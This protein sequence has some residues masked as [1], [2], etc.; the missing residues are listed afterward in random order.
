MTRAAL[1]TYYC[2]KQPTLLQDFDTLGDF[3]TAGTGAAFSIDTTYTRTG[4]GSLKMTAGTAATTADFALPSLT[5]GRQREPTLLLRVYCPAGATYT[6]VLVYLS[7]SA[8]F[9]AGTWCSATKN[10][11]E[12]IRDQTAFKSGWNN[13][14]LRRS[15]FAGGTPTVLDSSANVFVICRVR[16]EA[17]KGIMYFDSLYVDTVFRPKVCV[18]FDDGHESI[19]TDDAAY[20]SGVSAFEYMTSKGIPGTLYLQGDLLDQSGYLTSAQVNALYA[21]GWDIG[22][23]TYSGPV[24]QGLADATLDSELDQCDAVLAANGWERGRKHFAYPT[25]A[26]TLDTDPARLAARGFY[27]ART[28][29]ATL[30]NTAFDPDNIRHLWAKGINNGN[31][32]L[33]AATMTGAVDTA[34]TAGRTFMTYLHALGADTGNGYTWPHADFK[35]LIDHIARKRDLG[36]CDPV[37][38]SQWYDGLAGKRLPTSRL[39]A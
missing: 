19:F 27:T 4:S 24:V 14:L 22:N 7:T 29:Q 11:Y 15:D 38:I 36:L 9:G 25:G 3:T 35:T 26:F 6:S 30:T 32:L 2:R 16:L 13:L 8:G 18:M 34:I 5:F 12:G 28:I 37:T 39:S 17:N 10:V 31:S 21:A 33:S 1:P 23:H 20:G